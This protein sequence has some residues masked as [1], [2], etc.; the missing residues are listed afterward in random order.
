MQDQKAP[1]TSA[2][3]QQL[4]HAA[5]RLYA[6]GLDHAATI[7]DLQAT[8]ETKRL[9]QGASE[10]LIAEIDENK[11]ARLDGIDTTDL[12]SEIEKTTSRQSNAIVLKAKQQTQN[13]ELHAAW[14]NCDI[15]T[16]SR[17]Q[18]ARTLAT[19]RRILPSKLHP[20]A[21]AAVLEIAKQYQGA[22][23]TRHLEQLLQSY[24]QGAN[25]EE[26]QR[27]QVQRNRHLHFEAIPGGWRINGL[28]TTEGGDTVRN[29]LGH[30]A[31]L[32]RAHRINDDQTR[33]NPDHYLP[34]RLADALVQL[35]GEYNARFPNA[36]MLHPLNAAEPS[37]D[38]TQ[39]GT[40]IAQHY[41]GRYD[42][43]RHRRL[44]DPRLRALVLARDGGCI[45]PRCDA[46]PTTCEINHI[47]PWNKGGQTNL[48]NLTALCPHHHWIIDR[49]GS[50]Y[51]IQTRP[52]H[53]PRIIER[54]N[55]QETNGEDADKPP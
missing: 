6:H 9:L 20:H 49:A 29:A 23:L 11:Q 34:K 27:Q 52:G 47:Q 46:I 32:Q 5:Q 35:C 12:I 8:I 4:L 19:L 40:Y 26:I 28:L 16:N 33:R 53:A 18:A 1:L 51:H 50:K 7:E 13:P 55:R 14:A 41:D 31:K 22:E 43:K 38:P 2:D 17:N 45:F 25:A 36:R 30:L 10:K 54:A 24:P 3:L 15:S 37:M 39:T 48:D 42:L 44:A 21:S